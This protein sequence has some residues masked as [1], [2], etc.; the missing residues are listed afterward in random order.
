MR[1]KDSE[2]KNHDYYHPLLK[3]IFLI[4]VKIVSLVYF[5]SASD[6]YQRVKGNLLLKLA[7]EHEIFC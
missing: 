3:H 5:A 1:T 4:L 2:H 6:I 7:I